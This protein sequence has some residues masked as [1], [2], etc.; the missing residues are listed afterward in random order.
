MIG[1]HVNV[2]ANSFSYCE[3]QTTLADVESIDAVLATAAAAG[4][5]VFNAT[6]DFGSTCNDGSPNT[7]AVPADVPHATAVG[8]TSLKVGTGFTYSGGSWWDGSKDVPPGGQGGFGVSSFFAQ[9]SYQSTL[10]AETM[11]SVPDLSFVADLAFGPT[12]CQADAGGCPTGLLYGGTSLATFFWAGFT[13]LLNQELGRPAGFINP[14]VYPLAATDAF[15][16][17]TSLG[18]DAAHVGLGT[19]NIDLL[20]LALAG[21][22]PGTPSPTESLVL[23][24]PSLPL[25]P[26]TGSVTADGTSTGGI[27]VFVRDANGHEVPGKTVTLSNAGSHAVITPASGISSVANGAV[28]FTVKDTTVEDVTFTATDT[29]DSVAIAQTATVNFTGPPAASG[30]IFASPTSVTADGKSTTTITVKLKDTKGNPTPGKL[31]GLSQGNGASQVSATSGI[32]DSTGS[33]KFTATDGV[34][35]DVTYTAT[36]VTDSNLPVPNSATVDFVHATA[37]PSCNI[38]LG[39]AAAGFAVTTF[40]SGFPNNNCLGPIGLAFDPQGNLL[41]ADYS[42]GVLYKFPPTGGVAGPA[43]KSEIQASPNWPAWPL[44]LTADFMPPIR[45]TAKLWSWIQI[46]PPYCAPSRAYRMR[47]TYRSTL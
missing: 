25:T 36:D 20:G 19:P 29:T 45:G 21:A 33:A 34:E 35:Q 24:V 32:T 12:I 8:G 13:A 46:P 4:I 15:H 43:M 6:G 41:V 37:P 31:V 18:T 14:S 3:D 2:I 23:A 22:T 47:P 30:G 1:D 16:S 17:A 7:I 11:R 26:F 44:P 27:V 39:T 42:T 38:G 5:T 10:I 28:T 9:P 40:A